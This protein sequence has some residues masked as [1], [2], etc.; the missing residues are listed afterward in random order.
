MPK[1]KGVGCGHKEDVAT[2]EYIRMPIVAINLHEIVNC[3]YI[4][5]STV[6]GLISRG[7]MSPEREYKMK[8]L[9]LTTGRTGYVA[10]HIEIKEHF[11]R[12]GLGVH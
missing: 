12:P 5:L 9:S 1:W 2:R 11:T 7:L 8:V 6:L 4:V 10:K 3:Q